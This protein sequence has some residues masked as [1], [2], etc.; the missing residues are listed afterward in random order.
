MEL[1]AQVWSCAYTSL[2]FLVLLYLTDDFYLE[3]P[4]QLDMTKEILEPIYELKDHLSQNFPT[5]FWGTIS[6]LICLLLGIGLK[7]LAVM[8]LKKRTDDILLVNFVGRLILVIF[9]LIGAIF[10]LNAI[11]LGSAAGSI[12]A[13]AGVSAIIL[14]FAFKDIGEN[15]IA[16]FFLAFSRP[17]GN[18]D[19][20]ELEGI[21]G[22]V[23]EMSFRTTH[24]RTYDGR[25]IFLPN[26]MLVKNPLSNY[27][28]DGL[29]RHKF[30]VGLDYGDN[31]TL[32]MKTVL[33][34]L[35]KMS[36]LEHSK[37]LKPF[38]AID[39][40]GVSTVDLGIYFWVNSPRQKREIFE[41]KNEVME[42][43][44]EALSNAGFTLPAD[45]VELKIYQEGKP[46]PLRMVQSET[47]QIAPK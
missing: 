8:R 9:I 32:A 42:K 17:F 13:G 21:K 31:I 3:K 34:E 16:G 1:T 14:G 25:D 15:F 46:I 26:A 20:I 4:S 23:K 36:E 29:L 6:F 11:G 35:A 5:L 28:R 30:V 41:I 47:E 33:N 18:G 22:V 27:T 7:R 37:S 45:I 39:N 44:L 10:L 43:S 19:L 24:I 40:F 38:V 12:L 2:V